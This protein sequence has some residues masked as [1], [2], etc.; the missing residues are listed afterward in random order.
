MQFFNQ[1]SRQ[2][3]FNKEPLNVYTNN[4]VLS[5]REKTFENSATATFST[6]SVFKGQAHYSKES[7]AIQT[8][9]IQ[10]SVDTYSKQKDS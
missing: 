7:K 9:S 8:T 1:R 2:T 5:Y 10:V 3:N 6:N 4:P